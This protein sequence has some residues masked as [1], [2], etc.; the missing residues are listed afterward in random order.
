MSSVAFRVSFPAPSASCRAHQRRGDASTSRARGHARVAPSTSS[1]RVDMNPSVGGYRCGGSDRRVRM[2]RWVP[3]RKRDAA[4][5]DASADVRAADSPNGKVSTSDPE[6]AAARATEDWEKAQEKVDRFFLEPE[7]D[8]EATRAE[9]KRLVEELLLAKEAEIRLKKEKEDIAA[10]AAANEALL[11]EETRALLEQQRAAVQEIIEEAEADNEEAE[12]DELL[13]TVEEEVRELE[14]ELTETLGA[15]EV[16]DVLHEVE[17]VATEAAANNAEP[18]A[19]N[20]NALDVTAG[21]REEAAAAASSVSTDE[22]PATGKAD[23]TPTKKPRKWVVADV[24]LAAAAKAAGMDEKKFAKK[25][26]KKMKRK[27]QLRAGDKLASISTKYRAFNQAEY[28]FVRLSLLMSSGFVLL[29]VCATLML[30]SLL[31]T[32]G[33]KEVIFEG[34]MAWVHFNPVELV[35]AAVGALDRFLLGMVCL[36]FGLGSFEL[37]LAR[38]NRAGQVRDRRLKKLAWLKVSSID[39]LEQKVGE[40]IVAVMV[41]NLLE[42]SLH[43]S[44]NAPLDLVWAALAAVMSAGA[45]ALLHYAAGHGDHNHKDKGGHDS[46]AGLLH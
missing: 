16:D 15:V 17:E 13:A 23:P 8:P 25:F 44:Y 41:V 35:T 20:A 5:D 28:L 14:E 33:V 27:R 19:A 43:M 1:R 30:G 42:M 31:F 21:S 18:E 40:I 29:G 4:A 2:A 34:V 37:F 24:N 46:G 39:D 36:V 9:A 3:H 38:S 45:L 6:A 12:L 22:P 10:R 32:M 26:A 11:A 7:A